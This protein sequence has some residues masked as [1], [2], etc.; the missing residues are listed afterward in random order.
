MRTYWS[1]IG[2]ALATIF[3]ASVVYA[4]TAAQAPEKTTIDDCVA[5]KAAVEFPHKVHVD[6]SIACATLSPRPGGPHRDQHRRGPDLR[7]LPHHA[8]KGRDTGLL[9]DVGDQEPV[10]HQLRR[11]PQGRGQEE[12]R[13]EGA[14]QVRPVPPQG[15]IVR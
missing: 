5:K 14:D 7:C 8:G 10:P 1:R 13:V 6:A 4:A 9:A 12:R 2:V 3:L 11:L 15:L